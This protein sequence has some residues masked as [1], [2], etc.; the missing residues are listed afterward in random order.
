MGSPLAPKAREV[1]APLF[2]AKFKEFCKDRMSL[3]VAVLILKEP[4]LGIGAVHKVMDALNV[5]FDVALVLMIE[6]QREESESSA[7]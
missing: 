1:I 6:Y 3:D 7:G 2:P 4:A 5:P